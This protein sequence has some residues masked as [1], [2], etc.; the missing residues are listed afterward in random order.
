[1]LVSVYN[2]KVYIFIHTMGLCQFAYTV[3]HSANISIQ[4]LQINVNKTFQTIEQVLASPRFNMTCAKGNCLVWYAQNSSAVLQLARHGAIL[5]NTVQGSWI[6]TKVSSR[7]S[8][9]ASV[10][11]RRLYSWQKSSENYT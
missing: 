7:I 1:M 5:V 3:H 6:V 2:L 8:T 4:V 9:V 10:L 11:V